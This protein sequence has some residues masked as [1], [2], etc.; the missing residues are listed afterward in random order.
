MN[1]RGFSSFLN[2]Y[3]IVVGSIGGITI[4][5]LG[6]AFYILAFSDSIWS[7]DLV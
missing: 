7:K 4:A 6:L 3:S 2:Y 1:T 5:S